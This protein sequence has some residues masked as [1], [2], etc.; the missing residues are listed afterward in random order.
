[1][2]S[3][4]HVFQT[5]QVREAVVIDIF[6]LSGFGAQL[7]TCPTQSIYRCLIYTCQDSHAAVEVVQVS[8]VLTKYNT[9]T[10]TNK[11]KC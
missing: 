6:Y 5:S 1:M 2:Q 4:Q 8:A 3:R 10:T 9:K 11:A 7:F